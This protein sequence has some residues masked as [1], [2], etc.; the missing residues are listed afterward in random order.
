[1][2][3]HGA[4]DGSADERVAVVNKGTGGGLEWLYAEGI[5]PIVPL[6]TP[7]LKSKTEKQKPAKSKNQKVG[8]SQAKKGVIP[9]S[10]KP[11]SKN[12][13]SRIVEI[14]HSHRGES[15]QV[16]FGVADAGPILFMCYPNPGGALCSAL[17]HLPLIYSLYLLVAADLP[18]VAALN[19]H[20]S[21]RTQ[22]VSPYHSH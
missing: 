9:P 14:G 13:S 11:K 1:M 3:S 21:H 20:R 15:V 19:R 4:L 8:I 16:G 2:A 17:C 22:N 7:L 18:G 6:V 5:S 10:Q 12:R